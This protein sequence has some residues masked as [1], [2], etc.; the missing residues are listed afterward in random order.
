MNDICPRLLNYVYDSFSDVD[1]D[2]ISDLICSV[3]FNF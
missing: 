1:Q 3:F 2:S